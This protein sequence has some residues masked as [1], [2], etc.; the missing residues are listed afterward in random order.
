M[1]VALL[2]QTDQS[3]DMNCKQ[4]EEP[5]RFAWLLHR[6]FAPASAV[7]ALTVASVVGVAGARTEYPAFEGVPVA[8][9]PSEGVPG[10][11]VRDWENC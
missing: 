7:A 9:E 6:S 11:D 10:V 3:T 4:G 5:E 2:V 1:G 8:S